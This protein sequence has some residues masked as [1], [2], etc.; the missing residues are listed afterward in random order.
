MRIN[1]EKEFCIP[2][3]IVHHPDNH[4]TLAFDLFLGNIENEN[5]T[6]NR[7]PPRMIPMDGDVL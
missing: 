6:A 3:E 4:N 2:V 7:N 5:D 1:R